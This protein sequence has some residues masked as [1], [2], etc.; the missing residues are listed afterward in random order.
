VRKVDH[1]TGIATRRSLADPHRV[2]YDDPISGLRHTQPPRRSKSRETSTDHQPVGRDRPFQ[3]LHRT[4]RRQ[5]LIPGGRTWV[6]WQS[7]DTDS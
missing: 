7:R 1:E 6:S 5:D 3:R 4:D 2:K